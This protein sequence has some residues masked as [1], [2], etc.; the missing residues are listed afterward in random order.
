MGWDISYHPFKPEELANIYFAGVDDPNI[1][2]RLI[3][4]FG[5]PEFHIDNLQSAFL[6][7]RKFGPTVPFNAGHGYMAAIVAGH[8]R[9][10]WYVRG[11][12]LS[13]LADDPAFA[14]YFS[15]YR[16]L[17]PKEYAS[18][19]FADRLTENYSLG[20][21]LKNDALR[22]LH[23]DYASGG[24]VRAKLDALF[25]HGR[26]AVF[27]N[28]VAYA[29]EHDLALMEATEVIIPNPLDLNRS[30]CYSNLHNCVPD[31]ALLYQ[32]AAC[33][34]VA[35]ATGSAAGTAWDAAPKTEHDLADDAT[36][37]ASSPSPNPSPDAVQEDT[38]PPGDDAPQA[39]TW[40]RRKR[41]FLSR[42]FG[43]R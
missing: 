9:P 2:G 8:L 11:S 5:M 4:E 3:L 39:E 32:E 23:A 36:D 19:A 35:A 12:A 40:P 10:Y 31:G 20:V 29:L 27:M 37:P 7:A 1:A 18:L 33:G 16:P 14:R 24:P 26:L 13:F 28:A 6:H 43:K 21:L 22:L 25:S 38:L 15:A 30:E 34:Q 42:L 41:G 17:V